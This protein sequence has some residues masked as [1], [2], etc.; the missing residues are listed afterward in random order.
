MLDVRKD[1]N[2]SETI[3]NESSVSYSKNCKRQKKLN[4]TNITFSVGSLPSSG[5]IFFS[6][7]TKY[8]IFVIQSKMVHGPFQEEYYDVQCTV[9]FA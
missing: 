5:A 4:I 3:K 2:H 8:M 1:E 6:Y 9:E 7:I